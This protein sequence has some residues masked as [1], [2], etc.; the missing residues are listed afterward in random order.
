MLSMHNR[1]GVLRIFYVAPF[2]HQRQTAQHSTAEGK[3]MPGVFRVLSA[4]VSERVQ[5]SLQGIC[6]AFATAINVLP[7]GCRRSAWQ[8]FLFATQTE[9][10]MQKVRVSMTLQD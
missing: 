6:Q 3:R 1:S 5:R 8:K 4:W 10:Q 2:P 7:G 9:E